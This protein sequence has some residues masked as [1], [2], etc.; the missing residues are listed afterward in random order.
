MLISG[1]ANY[2]DKQKLVMYLNTF[3]IL[4]QREGAIRVRLA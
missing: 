4:K 2:M 1:N 3:K